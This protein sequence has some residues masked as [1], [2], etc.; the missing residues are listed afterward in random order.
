[1]DKVPAP[2]PLVSIKGE[3]EIKSKWINDGL[4]LDPTL[5]SI[6]KTWIGPI[7]Q[8]LIFYS[9]KLTYDKF[10][11]FSGSSTINSGTANGNTGRIVAQLL[12]VVGLNFKFER[13]SGNVNAVQFGMQMMNALF[14]GHKTN[15]VFTIA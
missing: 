3:K 11:R 2:T 5:A 8:R 4:I 13:W 9:K 1:M 14:F 6:F 10:G 7:L 15:G 12:I